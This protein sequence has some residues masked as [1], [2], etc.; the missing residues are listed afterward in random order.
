ML[1]QSTV[2]SIVYTIRVNNVLHL[3]IAVSIRQIGINFYS[4]ARLNPPTFC[5]SVMKN[6]VTWNRNATIFSQKVYLITNNRDICAS[7]ALLKDKMLSASGGFVAW[8]GFPH[9]L[10]PTRVPLPDRHYRL[11]LYA[12]HTSPHFY[13]DVYTHD[14]ESWQQHRD[15]DQQCE[16]QRRAETDLDGNTRIHCVR[17]Q[18]ACVSESLQLSIANRPLVSVLHVKFWVSVHWSVNVLLHWVVHN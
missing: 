6:K 4:A 7:F 5:H 14:C 16:V 1:Q 3:S 8:P 17:S 18:D 11:T 15:M 2:N 13:E 10:D 9:P 12:P